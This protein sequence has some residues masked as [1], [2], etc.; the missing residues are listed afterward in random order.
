MLPTL[1]LYEDVLSNG[2]QLTLPATPRMIFVV[3]GGV[4]VDGR[5][6]GCEAA[7]HGQGAVMV[8]AGPEGATCWRWDFMPQGATCGFEVR[9]C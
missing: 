3:H 6:L 4:T 7:W 9:H 1:G 8:T 2:A 5:S